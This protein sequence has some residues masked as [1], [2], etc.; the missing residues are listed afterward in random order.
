VGLVFQDPASQLVME[1]AGDD[2]AFG[3][4]NRAW[5]LEAMHR[6]VPRALAAVGLDGFAERQSVRLS[7]GEQQRLAIAGVLAAEPGVLV[8]DE[9]TANLDP[10]GTAT[11]YEWLRRVAAS[12][13]ATIVLVEHRVDEAWG[14]ADVVLALDHDGHPI[15]AGDPSEVLGRSRD[16]MTREGIWLPDDRSTQR[17]GPTPKPAPDPSTAAAPAEPVLELREAW[18]GYQ[19]GVPV[20]HGV[21]LEV[22]AGEHVALV[23]DNGSGKSTLLRLALGLLRPTAGAVRLLG[24]DPARLSPTQ[25]ATRAGFVAQDPELG[26]VGDTVADEIEL[27]LDP[28]DIS[29]AY[30]LADR[31]RLPISSFG[32]RSP[33][34]LSGGEKR[35][36][37]LIT[38]LARR[39]RLLVLDE[40]TYGQDR[41]GHDELV[42]ILRELAAEGTAVLAATHDERFVGDGA[43][44]GLE[45]DEGWLEA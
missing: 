18:Y 6:R 26:F 37:S 25:L 36:L 23:G 24:A 8:L 4:E 13:A 30:A 42:A 31:L 9:P 35:R 16:R 27:G 10:S 11:V 2:V 40:P 12:R 33:Y 17:R 19:R 39:P 38:A 32:D 3:L 7:G 34:R 43:N 45:I 20:L 15:D 22:E 1:R 29:W 14:L 28:G 44:R 5:P 21:S 41:H